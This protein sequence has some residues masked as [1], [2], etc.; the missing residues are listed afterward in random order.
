MYQ[1]LFFPIIII[2]PNDPSLYVFSSKTFGL[3]SVGGDN[4]YKSGLIYDSQG[5]IYSI[6][7]V[8]QV[9]N[10]SLMESL[11]FFQKMKKVDL[12][13]EYIQQITLD[14]LKKL[15]GQ[16]INNY[17]S[18]WEAKDVIDRIIYDVNQQSDF[19]H[20]MKCIE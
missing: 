18:Y 11:R 3:V 4:F 16:H 10:A 17:P 20:L 5:H 12:E 9:H 19:V 7:G 1:N 13:L 15:L 14:E 8:R 2:K 6:S